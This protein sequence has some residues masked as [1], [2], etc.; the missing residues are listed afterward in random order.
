MDG[1]SFHPAEITWNPNSLLL[2]MF[3]GGVQV[4]RKREGAGGGHAERLHTG[5]QR[6]M[7]KRIFRIYL[8]LSKARELHGGTSFIVNVQI[9]HLI[10]NLT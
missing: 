10:L 9:I 4:V 6:G 3:W 2:F 1:P 5:G 8:S 7:C